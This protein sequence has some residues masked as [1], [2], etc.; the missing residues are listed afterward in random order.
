MNKE[1]ENQNLFQ[2]I[3]SFYSKR[4]KRTGIKVQIW[5]QWTP[6]SVPHS[7]LPLSKQCSSCFCWCSWRWH[8]DLFSTYYILLGA[9]DGCPRD[10]LVTCQSIYCIN[11]YCKTVKS[12]TEEKW[13]FSGDSDSPN[14]LSSIWDNFY[15]S[16][17]QSILTHKVIDK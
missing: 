13:L 11:H 12:L 5:R 10:A 3:S 15:L 7:K 2:L 14:Y 17:A 4:S 8:L 1:T 6:S 9:A 16:P